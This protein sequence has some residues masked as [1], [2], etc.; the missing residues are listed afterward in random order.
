MNMAHQ[1]AFYIRVCHHLVN[2]ILQVSLGQRLH[3]INIVRTL[4]HASALLER[5]AGL[6]PAASGSNVWASGCQ[7]LPMG[8]MV[9]NASQAGERNVT[10]FMSLF[11][12]VV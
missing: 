6:S 3:H 5:P 2:P 8:M 4:T 10:M 1:Q 11:L 9:A 12:P 7:V